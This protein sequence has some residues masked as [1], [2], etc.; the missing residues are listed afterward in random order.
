MTG[1]PKKALDLL[2]LGRA[3]GWTVDTQPLELEIPGVAEA[4]GLGFL[5]HLDDGRELYF[6]AAYGRRTGYPISWVLLHDA[7]G[8]VVTA[9][10]LEPTLEAFSMFG[11][12]LRR[13]W[14]RIR[15]LRYWLEDPERL[16]ELW[17]TDG[18][19]PP[20]KTFRERLTSRRA[21]P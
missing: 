12:D 13:H 8:Y 15:D 11:A 4:I 14:T 5:R 1:L 7:D 16:V 20:R 18:D 2:E 21:E 19:L 3:T 17:T 10:V 6:V 9:E